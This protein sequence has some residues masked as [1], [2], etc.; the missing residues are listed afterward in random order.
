MPWVFAIALPGAPLALPG[1]EPMERIF[2]WTS[3]HVSMEGLLGDKS[4]RNGIW[5]V[6][7]YSI[8]M[9]NY[10][11]VVST[12][13]RLDW[14]FKDLTLCF[15]VERLTLRRLNCLLYNP[16]SQMVEISSW[17]LGA[18][19]QTSINTRS[20][21]GSKPPSRKAMSTWCWVKPESTYIPGHMNDGFFFDVHQF[22]SCCSNP[23]PNEVPDVGVD[24]FGDLVK[25]DASNPG[26]K[27]IPFS[28]SFHYHF[29]LKH[30]FGQSLRL[31]STNI[32]PF[33]HIN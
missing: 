27:S 10:R 19:S 31:T 9:L 5:C 17:K 7:P 30:F 13:G 2:F 15:K 8:A 1:T 4:S 32:L 16:Q 25:L 18:E 21:C 12:S 14:E 22:T 24:M 33:L 23:Y 3:H 6:H 28:L 20:S 11:R 26:P 29:C